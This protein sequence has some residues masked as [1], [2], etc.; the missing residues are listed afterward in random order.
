MKPKMAFFEK[1]VGKE[2]GIKGLHASMFKL[3]LFE[4]NS[5]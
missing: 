2:L 1:K 3:S 4:K 5:P